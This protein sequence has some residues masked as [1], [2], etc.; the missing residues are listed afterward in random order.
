MVINI[1]DEDGQYVCIS[2]MQIIPCDF[3]DHHLVSNWPTDV[4]RVLDRIQESQ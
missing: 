1:F 4:A 3:G 2:H